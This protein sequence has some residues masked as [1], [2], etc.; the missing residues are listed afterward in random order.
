MPVPPRES[1]APPVLPCEWRGDPPEPELDDLSYQHN[2]TPAARPREHCDWSGDLPEPELDD[3]AYQHNPKPAE[4]PADHCDWS[5]DSTEPELDDLAYQHAPRPK[6][7]PKPK[8]KPREVPAETEEPVP[9]PPVEIPHAEEPQHCHLTPPTATSPESLPQAKQPSHHA[10]FSKLLSKASRGKR[11]LEARI[12]R[13]EARRRAE[14]AIHRARKQLRKKRAEHRASRDEKREL[15]NSRRVEHHFRQ[16]DMMVPFQEVE[17]SSAQLSPERTQAANTAEPTLPGAQQRLPSLFILKK[18]FR[19]LTHQPGSSSKARQPSDSVIQSYPPGQLQ[20]D[21]ERPGNQGLIIM[22]LNTVTMRMHMLTKGTKVSMALQIHVLQLPMT[23]L[24]SAHRRKCKSLILPHGIL[25]TYESSSVVS[26]EK[27][28]SDSSA[29]SAQAEVHPELFIRKRECGH[30]SSVP[31]KRSPSAR[32]KSRPTTQSDDQNSS[33][34]K[35]KRASCLC[36]AM[37]PSPTELADYETPPFN[38]PRFGTPG[39]E[40]ISTDGS[41]FEK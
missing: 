22:P 7:K 18:G 20:K 1:S 19:R 29:E 31:R 10:H 23:G 9:G 40:D 14:K 13:H 28:G 26:V 33:P 4:T 30:S 38:T 34:G 12:R 15:R 41:Y 37:P 6:P 25:V 32:R 11:R 27:I 5:G 2:P 21:D 35:L 24:P 17:A 36:G 3:L 8:H 39:H 16:A